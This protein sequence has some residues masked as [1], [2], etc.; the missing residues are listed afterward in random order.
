M[1][2]PDNLFMFAKS[3]LSSSRLFKVPNLKTLISLLILFNAL[4]SFVVIVK[5]SYEVVG[6]TFVLGISC[7]LTILILSTSLFHVLSRSLLV[8]ID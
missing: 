8:I 2:K 7:L 3:L 6:F 1:F 5:N 4:W